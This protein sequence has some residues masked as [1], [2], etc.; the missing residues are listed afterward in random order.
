MLG[1][2]C[3]LSCPRWVPIKLR[4]N[5][6]YTLKVDMD[7]NS[8]WFKL[9]EEIKIIMTKGGTKGWPYCIPANKLSLC[10]S[11]LNCFKEI[12]AIAPSSATGVHYGAT[13]SHQHS[14]ITLELHSCKQGTMTK[15]F[16]ATGRS[17]T[18]TL[19]IQLYWGISEMSFLKQITSIKQ[20]PSTEKQSKLIHNLQ[21]IIYNLDFHYIK[22]KNTTKLFNAGKKQFNN[23]PTIGGLWRISG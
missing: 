12:K 18:S 22:Q 11:H 17:S 19:K 5:F 23:N 8:L 13:L 14:G 6:L 2:S 10:T 9:R 21:K 4:K 20:S 3:R 16:I 7:W 1:Y 15:P